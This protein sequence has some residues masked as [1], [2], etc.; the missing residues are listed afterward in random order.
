MHFLELMEGVHRAFA[1]L[2][3]LKPFRSNDNITPYQPAVDT[4]EKIELTDASMIR[5][6]QIKHAGFGI[7]P[8]AK[9]TVQQSLVG[10][11]GEPL[12][13]QPPHSLGVAPS[14]A[15]RLVQ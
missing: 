1:K 5:D 2:D 8:F 10:P 9:F 14:P 4:S 6:A 11:V 12:I 3:G 13:L 15:D 7:F